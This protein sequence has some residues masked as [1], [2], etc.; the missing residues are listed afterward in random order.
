MLVWNPESADRLRHWLTALAVRSC[1]P[2]S[3]IQCEIAMTREYLGPDE[4]LQLSYRPIG[5][6]ERFGATWDYCW[7]RAQ[8][9]VPVDMSGEALAIHIPY[10][11]G[12]LENLARIDGQPVCD[13]LVDPSG[14]G[15]FNDYM[16]PLKGAGPG[17]QHHLLC[18]GIAGKGSRVPDGGPS[19]PGRPK[20]CDPGDGQTRLGI[21]RLVHRN[22]DAR[23]LLIDAQILAGLRAHLPA[24]SLRRA[25]I[26]DALIR[27]L[28]IFD[29]EAEGASFAKSIASARSILA[30]ALAA[31]NGSTVTRLV[32]VGHGHLDL[33]WMWPVGEAQ[34]K[35]AR[36]AAQQLTIC[37]H[38]PEHRFNFAQPQS[39]AWLKNS[40]PDLWEGL[41]AA[42]KRGQLVLDGGLWIEPDT[43]C[44]APETLVRSCRWGRRFLR[45]HFGVESQTCF[46][47]DVFGYTAI[48]PQILTGCGMDAFITSKLSWLHQGGDPMPVDT[49]TWEGI[50]GSTVRAHLLEDYSGNPDVA[51]YCRRANPHSPQ[52]AAHTRVMMYG[53]GDGGGGPVSEHLEVLRRL[54]D[55]EGCP[56]VRT[57]S[58]RDCLEDIDPEI[59]ERYRYVGELYLASHRG[60]LTTQGRL[61]R[62]HRR[63]EM[64]QRQAEWWA[65]AAMMEGTHMPDH[66]ALEAN[67]ERILLNSFHDILP[68]TGIRRVVDEGVATAQAVIDSACAQTFA[69]TARLID[70]PAADALTCFNDLPWQR[71]VLVS[72]PSH[73]PG[74]TD[75]TVTLT[76]QQIDDALWAAVNIPAGGLISLHPAQSRMTDPA[77]SVIATKTGLENSCWRVQLNA[78]GQV[79]SI[80]DKRNNRELLSG[81]G[82]VLRLYR[83]LPGTWDAWDIDSHHELEQLPLDPS[84]EISVRASGPLM[85]QVHVR[86]RFGNSCVDRLLT[87]EQDVA[88]LNI[89]AQIDWQETHRLLKVAWPCAVHAREWHADVGWGHV[90]RPT[91]RNRQFD[92]DRFEAACHRW[93]ALSDSGRG[94]ALLN[95][96]RYG[97]GA[98]GNTMT[99]S[100]LRAPMAPD[101]DADKGMHTLRWAFTAWEGPLRTATI[102]RQA[103]A[104]NT[105]VPQCPGASQT[106]SLIEL[107]HHRAAV[108]WFGPSE[109]G[110]GDGCL[111]LVELK[112]SDDTVHLR[113]GWPVTELVSCDFEERP[114]G[115]CVAADADGWFVIRLSAFQA[116]TFRF[117]RDHRSDSPE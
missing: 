13:R 108:D 85:G 92:A 79:A 55:L 82:D 17:S 33:A 3:E 64:A 113:L 91:H 83:D 48:L 29:P 103:A 45:D 69:A 57:G 41:R 53:Y 39:L 47:P 34:R 102:E 89:S 70:D 44:S 26:E 58:F 72:L 63:S 105:S 99:L 75:A 61:K 23:Q 43:N 1:E 56:R 73:W 104:F 25:T 87:L 80:V 18:E 97:A 12:L 50:D 106:R 93:T 31:T 68:G 101:H 77:A 109:D 78:N 60:T 71:R 20:V 10:G 81:P 46:L 114:T 94:C 54:R 67:W 116:R 24:G 110:T 112:G 86:T 115:P 40:D 7:V 88:Q 107:S 4:A 16:L 74:S 30:P 100:L 90:A 84:V 22:A 15:W 27:F 6:E 59:W 117:R 9:T 49:F 8:F 51:G 21:W 35:V 32:A 14:E 5:P 36:T 111:R 96:G 42:A 95:D 65:A 37:E 98:H 19:L 38:Y 11:P 28:L 52:G 76:T 2:I 62:L 66:S